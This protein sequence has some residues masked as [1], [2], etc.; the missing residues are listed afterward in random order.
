MCRANAI[1]LLARALW[2]AALGIVLASGAAAA[3]QGQIAINTYEQQTLA[4]SATQRSDG[5]VGLELR[6]DMARQADYYTS[7]SIPCSE[8]PAAGHPAGTCCTVACNPALAALP[9]GL[10]GVPETANPL[11]VALVDMLDGRSG[12]RTERPPKQ[13]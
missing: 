6:A 8:D 1:R 7:G 13:A 11:I 10:I 12:D 9:M 3:H 4:A 2:I 5:A